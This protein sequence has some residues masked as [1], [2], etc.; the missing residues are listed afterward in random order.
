MSERLSDPDNKFKNSLVENIKDLCELLPKLNI[1]HDPEL[2]AVV[3]EIQSKLTMNYPQTLRDNDVI[4][5]KTAIEAQKILNKM[6][7]YQI[8]TAA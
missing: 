5:N 3:N 2:D 8:Q 4:R 1:T 6:R 7:H